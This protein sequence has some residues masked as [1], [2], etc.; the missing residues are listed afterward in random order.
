MADTFHVED[1]DME[2]SKEPQSSKAWLNL[3]TDAEKAF[4]A[5]QTKAD[6]IDKVYAE[7]ERMTKATR[8]RE[9][10]LFWSNVQVLGPSIYAR[11]PVPV[12]VPKFKDRRPLYRVSSELL[13]RSTSV[14]FDMAGINDTMI[15]LRDDLNIVGRGVAWVRYETKGDSE[16]SDERV[17]IDYIDRKDFLHDP[18][19]TWAEVGWV[20]RRG[21]MTHGEMEKRFSKDLADKA[22]Y[23]IQKDD[24]DRGAADR[25][26][27]CGVWEIWSKTE[28]RVVWVTEGVEELL[29][30]GKP[31]LDLEG[32]F[33]CPRPV[34]STLQRRSL[35]PI[36][37]MVYYKDQLEEINE[38][39]ARIHLLSEALVVRG[40]YPSGGGEIGDA[41]EAAMKS[42]D[43]RQIMVPISNWAAFGSTGG[44]PVIWLPID[45]IAQV[46]TGLVEL[47]RQIIDDVYQIMGLSDIMRGSTEA[48]ET[49]G[50]QQ[51]KAQY[52]SVRIRDKQNELVRVARDLVRIAAEIMAENFDSD[53]LVDMSQ[54]EIPT[55]R[56]IAEQV[57]QI[58]QRQQAI[59]QKLQDIQTDPQSMAQVQE[60]P[61]EAQ[62]AM[63]EAQGQMRQMAAE[64][65][66]LQDTPTIEKVMDFLRDQR[67]RPFVLDIET[68]STIQPDEDAE[69]ERRTEFMTAFMQSSQALAQ[70]VQLE[71][72][73][74]PLAGEMLRFVLAPFRAGRQMEGAIDDFVDQMVERASQPQPNPEAEAM[75]AQAQMEQQKLQM[76]QAKMQADMQAQQADA[77]ARAQE[78]ELKAQIETAKADADIQLKA[79]DAQNNQRE[80]QARLEQ[81]A[82]QERREERKAALELQKMQMEMERM[83]MDAAIKS[84]QAVQQA[85]LSERS[86]E[87]N[88]ALAQQKAQ[89]SESRP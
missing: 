75:Q 27:K 14:A 87:Q 35:I 84:T 49:L 42:N 5:Y 13:E 81:I 33:P 76:E 34:Y 72:G 16:T 37:D 63:Q 23:A 70:M 10:A 78:M 89:Q 74:A 61:E 7:L 83:Q 28:D 67:I 52:G 69:K 1:E 53:T 32:F 68:D 40:F 19:R 8:D 11:P 30:E 29:D 66:K 80:S 26:E 2:P 9:F 88:A 22:A 59:A 60:N 17:C 12:V 79:L 36:P 71:P 25:R 57:K 48:N 46:V 21:W 56:E 77:Q 20:A 44:D 50:A 65:A 51:I 55:D 45:M 62:Q 73:A 31:H 85:E 39:T 64:I 6:N 47:R 18:A 43:N 38:L 82:A 24:R 3:I 54:L 86:F 41:I 4:N 58:E 15:A